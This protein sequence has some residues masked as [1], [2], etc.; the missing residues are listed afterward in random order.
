[1]IA[2]EQSNGVVSCNGGGMEPFMGGS[3]AAAWE[4]MGWSCNGCRGAGRWEFVGSLSAIS[5]SVGCDAFKSEFTNEGIMVE[6][7]WGLVS[8]LYS[9]FQLYGMNSGVLD[10]NSD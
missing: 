2:E 1:M 6:I 5:T 9:L 3:E 4:S 10:F 8:I 7:V